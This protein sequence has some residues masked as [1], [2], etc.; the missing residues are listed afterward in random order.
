MRYVEIDIVKGIAVIC[1]IIFHLFYF[2]NQYGFKEI[3]YDTEINGFNISERLLAKM[4]M[5]RLHPQLVPFF[6]LNF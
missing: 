3:K 6:L 5:L 1:M 2:P 4:N